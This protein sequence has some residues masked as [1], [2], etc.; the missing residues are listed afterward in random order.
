MKYF[1]VFMDG[2]TE[3]THSKRII[4]SRITAI[5][6]KIN[7]LLLFL[8][9]IRYLTFNFLNIK[10]ITCETNKHNKDMTSYLKLPILNKNSLTED[11]F[12]DRTVFA[13][14]F[15]ER[16]ILLILLLELLL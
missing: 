10:I 14:K 4:K 9:I 12:Q 3:I 5:F 13:L 1:V 16:F 15:L 7:L 8:L 2:R 6:S 11:K